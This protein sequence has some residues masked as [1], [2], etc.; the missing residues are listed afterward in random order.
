MKRRERGEGDREKRE[1][2][3]HDDWF[4]GGEDNS[5]RFWHFLYFGSHGLP[6]RLSLLSSYSVS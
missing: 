3:M 2:E 5:E 6:S 4:A 1:I